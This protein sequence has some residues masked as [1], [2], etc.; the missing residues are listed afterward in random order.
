[1]LRE[2]GKGKVP[3]M[4]ARS[5]ARLAVVVLAFAAAPAL[6]Q[7]ASLAAFASADAADQ[8]EVS[9]QADA[10]PLP[11]VDESA[12]LGQALQF[13]PSNLAGAAPT[14]PLRLPS[15]KKQKTFDV[16]RTDSRPDGSGTVVVKQTLPTE[17]DAKIGADLGLAG[18]NPVTYHP[19]APL[20]VYSRES[21][22]GAAW[23]SIGLTNM[24]SV[25]ARVDP[26]NDQGRLAGTLKH[27]MPVGTSASLTLQNSVSVTETFNAQGPA[28]PAGLPL[29]TLPQDGGTAPAQVFGNEQ[30]VKFN[31]LPTGTTLAAGLASSSIDPVMHNKFSAEQKL[32]GPLTVTTSVTDVGQPTV[33]KSISAGFKLSW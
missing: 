31:V 28:A 30:A 21:G 13:D 5:C 3:D 22:G 7:E 9:D 29:R 14:K 12:L 32:L 27:S 2:V 25:D 19:Q 26:T 18:N 24:A 23:A 17:W 16:S 1:M 4:R 20:D 10:A 15:L 11:G 6:A 8:A 33:N